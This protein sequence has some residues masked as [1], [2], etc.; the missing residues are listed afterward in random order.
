ME[1]TRTTPGPRICQDLL[2]CVATLVTV[3][4]QAPA[5]PHYQPTTLSASFAE[6]TIT[7]LSPLDAHSIPQVPPSQLW[8]I[9]G[10]PTA[11]TWGLGAPGSR[12]RA[13][14]SLGEPR[15]DSGVSWF[16]PW[17]SLPIALPFRLCWSLLCSCMRAPSSV[18]HEY[19]QPSND[20]R[21]HLSSS[22]RKWEGRS[23]CIEGGSLGCST[24]PFC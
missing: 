20:H 9:K 7:S 13:G 17:Y 11:A 14:A 21:A 22:K 18:W 4:L 15:Q 8:G 6:P 10:S 16:Y 3:L 2:D 1:S 5:S 24:L 19:R 23:C 12:Q